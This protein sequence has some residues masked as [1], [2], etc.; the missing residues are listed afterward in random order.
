MIK[1]KAGPPRWRTSSYSSGGNPDCVEVAPFA[2]VV[3]VRDSKDPDGP[4]LGFGAAEW[5]AFMRDV[6]AGSHELI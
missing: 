5:A 6:R 2:A 3:A 1:H 4:R